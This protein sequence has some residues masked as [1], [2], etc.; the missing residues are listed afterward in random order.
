L[1]IA[2]VAQLQQQAAAAQEAQK[3]SSQ[4]SSG[5][6]D[7]RH[8]HQEE[9]DRSEQGSDSSSGSIDSDPGIRS[10][11][12][13]PR[14]STSMHGQHHQVQHQCGYPLWREQGHCLLVDTN[15]SLLTD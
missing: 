11:V 5:S 10:C 7:E 13:Y 3:D 4:S 6:E 15:V 2:Q 8:S 9:E 14:A 12:E 1:I